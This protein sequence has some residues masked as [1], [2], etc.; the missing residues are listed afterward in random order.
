MKKTLQ[1]LTITFVFLF[2]QTFLAQQR[3]IDEIFSDVDITYDVIYGN[4]VTVFPTLLGG[5][6]GLQ[7][8]TEEWYGDGKVTENFT[9]S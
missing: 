7:A 4:N 3:Y 2:T 9:T 5:D 6:P 1:L 8:G